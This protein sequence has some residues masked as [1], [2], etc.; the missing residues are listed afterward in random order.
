MP[1]ATACAAGTTRRG[2]RPA[3]AVAPLMLLGLLPGHRICRLE[4]A[5]P[6][7]GHGCSLLDS[8]I[9][10][11]QGARTA[12]TSGARPWQVRLVRMTHGDPFKLHAAAAFLG[13]R[14]VSARV[15]T[16]RVDLG[17]YLNQAR[18]VPWSGVLMV[19]G[20]SLQRLAT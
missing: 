6:G 8:C 3:L 11:T 13:A 7:P 14:L 19:L 20:S 16:L 2:P 15:M 18:S 10:A 5:R 4:R 17:P 9:G 12:T 1:E